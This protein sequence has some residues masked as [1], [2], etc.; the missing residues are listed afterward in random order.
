MMIEI[1]FR[2]HWSLF[3]RSRHDLY[4]RKSTQRTQRLATEPKR[5]QVIQILK[6]RQLGRIMFASYTINP[7]PNEGRRCNLS[8]HSPRE[9]FLIRRPRLRLNRRHSS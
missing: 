9:I 5:L 3:T 8:H 4:I 6:R 1:K 2:C 7:R